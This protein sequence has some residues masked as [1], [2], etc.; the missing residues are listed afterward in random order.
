MQWM[1]MLAC[2]RGFIVVPGQHYTPHQTSLCSYLDISLTIAQPL[3]KHDTLAHNDGLTA[4]HQNRHRWR[5]PI[6]SALRHRHS[7][8]ACPRRESPLSVMNDNNAGRPATPSSILP[9][10]AFARGPDSPIRFAA[11]TGAFGLSSTSGSTPSALSTQLSHSQSLSP[12]SPQGNHNGQGR[13]MRRSSLLSLRTTDIETHAPQ[14]ISPT[15]LTVEQH[16]SAPAPAQPQ[17]RWGGGSLLPAM[18]R[19]SSAPP[20]P[21]EG[22]TTSTPPIHGHSEGSGGESPMGME[23]DRPQWQ[24]RYLQQRRTSASSSAPHPHMHP[25]LTGRPLPGALLATL[26]SESAPLEHEMRSEA[27][28][29]RLLTSHPSALPLTPR[30][31]RNLRVSR[32]RFPEMVDEDEDDDRVPLG[33]RWQ[34]SDT[35]SDDMMEEEWTAPGSSGAVN[36]AFASIMDLDRPASSGS[37]WHKTDSG[38]STPGGSRQSIGGNGNGNG[39]HRVAPSPGTG[40]QLPTAFGGLGMGSATPLGSPT[41]EKA[42]LGASPTIGMMQYRDPGRPGKRKAASEDRFDPYKRPRGSSPSPFQNAALSP[43]KSTSIPIPSSPSHVP[44]LSSALALGS[45]GYLPLSARPKSSHHPYARPMSSRSRAASPALSIGSTSGV[46]STSIKEG[47]PLAGPFIPTGVAVGE[48]QPS[49]GSLG[50]LSIGRV[51]EESG[52]VDVDE[53]GGRSRSRSGSGRDEA[54]EED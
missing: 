23:E 15:S 4:H 22:L 17:P 32:G 13:R 37:S 3:I 49:L 26:I 24:P 2:G 27:R 33:S 40:L 34:E 39:K 5:R 41:I 45:P 1:L 16:A 7:L 48:Q 6:A 14:E 47:K 18:Q 53:M 38:K 42:E 31:R 20:I 30:Q 44:A 9:P 11:T 35:D 51:E 8:A 46:L 28:L 29:Q 52:E 21:L 50:L 25:R 10:P 36:T 43:S 12:I 19:V 54:M